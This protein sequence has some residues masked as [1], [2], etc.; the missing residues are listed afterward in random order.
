MGFRAID[1]E[2]LDLDQHR[3]SLRDWIGQLLNY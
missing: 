1:A 3:T 2:R